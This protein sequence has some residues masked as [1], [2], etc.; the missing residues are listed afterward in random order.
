MGCGRS[1]LQSVHPSRKSS[2]KNKED[3]REFLLF[4]VSKFIFNISLL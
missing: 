1:K 4:F 2:A 3:T